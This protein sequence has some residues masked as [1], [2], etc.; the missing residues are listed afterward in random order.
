[1]R[2]EAVKPKLRGKRLGESFSSCVD[3]LS[4]LTDNR[5]RKSKYVYRCCSTGLNYGKKNKTN[6]YRYLKHEFPHSTNSFLF[7][8]DLTNAK[9][10]NT[11]RIMLHCCTATLAR[12]GDISDILAVNSLSIIWSLLQDFGEAEDSCEETVVFRSRPTLVQTHSFS[13]DSGVTQMANNT[14]KSE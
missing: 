13:S 1:M 6:R 3:K 7:Q 14:R 5:H 12:S 8:R 2:L 4:Y 9:V 11:L 10:K